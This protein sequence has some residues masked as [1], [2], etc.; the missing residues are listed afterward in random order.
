MM[1]AR[2]HRR[3]ASGN[4]LLVALVLLIGGALAWYVLMSAPK[5]QRVKPEVQPRLVEVTA[6]E[7]KDARPF[8]PA[9]GKVMAADSVTL[10]AQVSAR[11]AD[12]SK[13]ALPGAYLAKGSLLATL[14]KTDFELQVQQSLAALTQAQADL[15]I[16]QGQAAL[17]REE[18][19]LAAE[20][21]SAEERALVL[22]EPQLAKA[23][24][25]LSTA[26]ASLNQARLNLARTEVRMPFAGQIMARHVSTGSQ[27]SSNTV[28]F[29]LVSTERYWIEV[30]VPRAFLS[31]LDSSADAT[32]SMSG[33]QG[34]TRSARVLNVL[35]DVDSS[36]RQA[37]VVLEL[38]QPLAEGQPLVLVNDFIDVQLPG[39]LL[40]GAV[41]IDVRH[42]NDDD[43]LWVVNNNALYKRKVNVLYRGREQAWLS[44]AGDKSKDGKSGLQPGDQLL[45]SR[46]DSATEGMPV[47]IQNEV[48][49]Q[50]DGARP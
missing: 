10:T 33:W 30:K 3:P 27:V 17:A 18:Y 20:K 23:K 2:R 47:R 42:L 6:L 38:D 26:R 14:E 35:P 16:E 39:R 50:A 44:A 40:H 41:T 29:D 49:P 34:Q 19:A 12:I 48:R 1:S 45:L 43:T 21:L 32:L 13:D 37:K 9:G 15:D 31:L 5:P 22:R 46:I 4:A 7:S 28:L 11:V 25:A 36:D 24:A 8:W